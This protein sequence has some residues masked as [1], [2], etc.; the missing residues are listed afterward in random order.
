[1]S[2]RRAGQFTKK[3]TP[4]EELPPFLRLPEEILCGVVKHAMIQSAPDEFL[5]PNPNPPT[6]RYLPNELEDHQIDPQLR[7]SDLEAIAN[8]ATNS[9]ILRVCQRLY[10]IGQNIV[11]EYTVLRI[12]M[13]DQYVSNTHGRPEIV[14][15]A[16]R[17]EKMHYLALFSKRTS[18]QQKFSQLV[19]Q[20]QRH[21]FLREKVFANLTVLSLTYCTGLHPGSFA[22]FDY[23]HKHKTMMHEIP[24]F[25]YQ[26]P[27]LRDFFVL[28]YNLLDH[29]GLRSEEAMQVAIT[30]SRHSL[31]HGLARHFSSVAN[32]PHASQPSRGSSDYSPPAQVSWTP[33]SWR[34]IAT[35]L[36]HEKDY[37]YYRDAFPHSPETEYFE[38]V[39]CE[40]KHSGKHSC[41]QEN[42]IRCAVEWLEKPSKK[43]LRIWVHWV[44]EARDK[45]ASV[46][47]HS[48]F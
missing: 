22:V 14:P 46:M 33:L 43:P 7:G 27:T 32:G 40:Q 20:L 29:R 44:R 41:D 21:S 4:I 12:Q 23:D 3:P 15:P 38:M 28:C 10:H 17:A 6:S 1:M 8:Q 42:C 48:V 16:F 18:K 19:Q 9:D 25:L 34:A 2:P 47:P 31:F 26:A 30:H 24:N 45:I 11:G 13:V 35:S 37:F 39:L 5:P 36:F